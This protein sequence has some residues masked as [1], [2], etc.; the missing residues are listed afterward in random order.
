MVVI[1]I[2]GVLI[3]IL[4]PAVMA[5]REAARRMQCQSNLKQLGLAAHNFESTHGR[6]PS[7]GWG[8]RWQGFPDISSQAGQPGSWSYSLLPFLEQ[9]ALYE[10]G[11]YQSSPASRDQALRQRVNSPAAIYNCPSRRRGEPLPFHPLCGT[12]AI[13]VGV[14]AWLQS[15]VRCDYAVNAGDG[16]P[17]LAELNYWPLNYPGPADLTEANLLTSTNS[18]PRP[19][20]DW[21]GISWLLRGVRMA[22]L[23]DG[24]SH[25]FLFGEKYIMRDA[26]LSGEDF[27]DNE[28]NYG[29]FNNDNHRSTHP[30]WPLMRDKN[31]VMSVGSFGSAHSSGA[32]FVLADGSV[33]FVAYTI[34]A[35]IYRYLG[36]RYD[37]RVVEVPR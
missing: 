21:S 26:Y 22:E 34:D 17:D 19:P 7:G 18:W 14:T 10:L 11:D 31:G 33:H 37:A 32:N 3:G 35:E 5:A 29:G 30:Q 25:V 24:T 16:A 13:P 4:L 28:P 6:F 12:C 27:G 8:Y 15:A 36:N 2:I 9:S 1:A 23:T 20:A